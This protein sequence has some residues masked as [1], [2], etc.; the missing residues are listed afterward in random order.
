MFK[1]FVLFLFFSLL[2]VLPVFAEE[3][4]LLT[5]SVAYTVESAREIAFDG[6][7]LKI[8]KSEIIPFRIDENN[9]ENKIALKNN[10]TVKGRTIMAFYMYGGKVNGYVVTY[11][12]RP[13]YS[14]YYT[15]G[16]YLVAIDVDDKFQENMFP[17]KI[18]KYSPL[19]GNLISIALYVSDD[20]Q[21]AYTKDGKLKAHW[22][23][24]VAYNEKGKI[25]ARRSVVSEVP[26][27]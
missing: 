15:I 10:L 17:Y 16:G 20:E 7:S 9:K 2:F 22:V 26:D 24:S 23:G 12:E 3:T 18:G 19:T 13:E 14:Y 6:V 27:I 4:I 25:I 11:D 21:Y 5:G 1:R 8:D